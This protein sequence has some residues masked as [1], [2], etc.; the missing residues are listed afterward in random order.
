M[1]YKLLFI[2]LLGFYSCSHSQSEPK[3][4]FVRSCEFVCDY[5][6]NDVTKWAITCRVWGLLKYHHPNVTAGKPDWDEILLD[7][8]EDIQSS[9]SIETV[10]AALKK[11]LDAAGEY[12]DQRDDGRNDSLNMN[13]NL[14]WIDGSFLD[15]NLSGELKKIASQT[16]EYPS[17]YSIEFDMTMPF[18]IVNE[19][20][21]E[22]DVITS[23]KYRLLA[24]FKYWNVIYYFFPHKYLMD[25]SWDTILSESIFPF[26]NV[27]DKRSCQIAFLKLA[28]SLNDSHAYMSIAADMYSKER[29]EIIEKVEGKTLVKIDGGGLNKGDIVDS[30]GK[31]DINHIRDSLS[32]LVPASTQGKKEYLINCYVA[33]MIFFHETDITITRNGQKLTL[34]TVPTLFEKRVP[35]S[36][37]WISDDT[38]YIDLSILKTEEIDLIFQIFSDAKGIIFDLRKTGAYNYDVLQLEYYLCEQKVINYFPRIYPDMAHP[39]AYFWVKHTQFVIPDNMEYTPY[40]GKIIALINEQTQSAIEARAWLFRTCC[41]ASL[42]GRPTSGALENV[43]RISLPGTNASFSGV[44]AFLPDGTELQ[45]KGII[46][47]IEVYPT[48]ESIK[49]GKDEILEAAIEYLNK[50]STFA[51]SKIY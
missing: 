7:R 47:D 4:Y 48:M 30:V 1:R 40:K 32:V 18:T 8:L 13:R 35:S 41:R 33:D 51:S 12:S 10:N 26:I 23:S 39:G 9:S 28:A 17:C 11:M 25:K 2:I 43:I 15:N 31:R 49:A 5:P 6:F 45:R 21:Y 24:L 36:Y 29:A 37:K 20:E 14:C 46:P 34:H 16:I 44:G 3:E 50:N 27:D 19:K 42:I 38:G 22:W